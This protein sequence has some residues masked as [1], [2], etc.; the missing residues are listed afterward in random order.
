[1]SGTLAIHVRLHDGRYDGAGDWPPAPAR[2]FQALVAGAGL[3]GS[4][5]GEVREALAWLERLPAPL[6][7]APL[8]WRGQPV[9]FYMPNNDLDAVAGDP[10]R[11]AKIR[12]ATKVFRPW[13]FDAAT[14]FLYAW[15]FDDSEADERHARVLCALAERLYQFGRG[16]DM[17]WAWGE[18][19]DAAG[20]D[21]LCA[22]Y[23]GCIHRASIGG[24]G[25]TLLCPH[26][27]SLESLE[28]RYE[29]YGR[30]FDAERK[31]RTVKVAFRQPPRPSFRSIGY[32]NPPS[33]R[34]YELRAPSSESSF[35]PWPL[36]QVSKLVVCLR[37]GAVARLKRALPAQHAEIE[38]V[39]VGR[40]PD[41]T[42]DGPTEARVRIV[43]LPSIGHPHADRS[44]RRVLVEVPAECRLRA[45]D[46]HW[47]FSS[48]EPVDMETGELLGSILTPTTNESML[49]HYGL[50][51]DARSR[52]WR[53]V[54]PAALSGTK[55]SRASGRVDY[56]ARAAAAVVHA[57]RRAGRRRAVQAIR[58]QREPFEANGERAETFV[59][60]TRFTRD[61]LWHVEITFTEPVSGPLVIGDGRFLGL[62]VMRPVRQ[63]QGVHVL[64]IEEGLAAAPDPVELARALRRAVMAR[65]QA[66]LGPRATLPTFFTGHE[67]DGSPGRAARSS[68]LGFVFDPGTLGPAR[69]LILAPHVVERRSPRREEVQHLR[70]LEVALSGLRE[71]RAGRSGRL[72]LRASIVDDDR[73]P[74]FA[75]SREWESV[76]PYQVTRHVKRV[77]ALE[78]FSADLVA[79]CS[80]R[81]LPKPQVRPR[82]LRG[83]PGVG[84]IGGAR[85]AFE[86]PVAGPIV[87]GR[88][89]H[90][91]GGLFM[92]VRST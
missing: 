65:V 21:A 11:I 35:A 87:L 14:P 86:R 57:L 48:L 64:L 8:A 60:G 36:P 3:G 9:M 12:T 52:I 20:L 25:N 71:L 89:R 75:L 90:L 2:L 43:P 38:R 28:K 40:K 29:A 74:A 32:D 72:T 58:V 15:P 37:E 56:E 5:G 54:T 17:A 1:M 67:L 59:T 80:R 19:I 55:P 34:L 49:S 10:R 63:S 45:D 53:T 83:V 23:S 24:D 39:L 31:G 33:R 42:N 92:G 68:H 88:S 61:R 6:I 47:A 41:G 26:T 91:G 84:L 50:D 78:A 27:G 7:G 22:S 18:V 77:G 70:D 16:V 82:E 4:L 81:S 69:L 85:L 30:R 46:V 73:D 44:I 66:V 79:E 13:L 76:T 62:G 51:E